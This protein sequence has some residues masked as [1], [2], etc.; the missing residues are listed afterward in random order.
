L[1]KLEEVDAK[2]M[3]ICRKFNEKYK[4]KCINTIV[5]DQRYVFL[6]FFLS[7]TAQ[8][9]SK[10]NYFSSSFHYEFHFSVFK[11]NDLID[12]LI[13][14]KLVK[15]RAQGLALGRSLINGHVIRHVTSKR[16]FHDGF[17]LYKFN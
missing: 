8:F 12:W 11:G 3:E 15:N 13:K 16:H 6:P 14:S 7:K 5:K 17:H 1:P 9:K 4:E 10:V 2:T